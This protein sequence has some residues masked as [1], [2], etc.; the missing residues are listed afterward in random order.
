MIIT[1]QFKD[2]NKVFKGKTYDYECVDSV[3]PKKN[4][5]IRMV[6]EDCEYI[7]NGTRVKVVDVKNIISSKPI[8]KIYCIQDT[9]DY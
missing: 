1:V 5:I 6:N 2:K 9:L 8:Q 3:I 4:D 7:C